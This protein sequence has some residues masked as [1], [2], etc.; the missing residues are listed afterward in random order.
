M[1][2]NMHDMRNAFP[3]DLPIAHISIV[4]ESKAGMIGA[5]RPASSTNHDAVLAA[6]SQDFSLHE[7]QS[8]HVGNKAESLS[9]TKLGF[10]T[11]SPVRPES[12]LLP[13]ATCSLCREQAQ[14]PPLRLGRNQSDTHG[15]LL[16]TSQVPDI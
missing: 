15:S 4:K 2:P 5:Y 12:F 13:Q 10:A 3:V 14:S 16:G 8:A 1:Q 7:S 11:E 6:Q 9:S